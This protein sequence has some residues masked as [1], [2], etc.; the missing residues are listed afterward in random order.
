M[1]NVSVLSGQKN[2]WP[3]R[4]FLHW[5]PLSKQKNARLA[6]SREEWRVLPGNCGRVLLENGS[7][8]WGH[9]RVL[10]DVEEF[11]P[12]CQIIYIRFLT[13]SRDTLRRKRQRV[14]QRLKRKW[15]LSLALTG[16]TVRC[17]LKTGFWRLRGHFSES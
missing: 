12:L 9:R 4:Y 17:G 10:G 5:L 16:P 3:L 6:A 11:S 14:T 7:F 15:G 2:I 8:R 13:L 1:P